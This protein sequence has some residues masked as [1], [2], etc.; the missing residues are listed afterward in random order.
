MPPLELAPDTVRTEAEIIA[1]AKSARARLWGRSVPVPIKAQLVPSTPSPP[2]DAPAPPPESE[3]RAQV[4]KLAL[5]ALSPRRTPSLEPPPDWEVTHIS[6]A[7][8]IAA[9]CR[10]FGISAEDFHERSR[11]P[12]I[13]RRRQIV[14]YLARKQGY[15]YSQIARAFRGQD[16]TT[17][18]NSV[19]RIEVLLESGDLET[20]SDVTEIATALEV[21]FPN[22]G[23]PREQKRKSSSEPPHAP[24]NGFPWSPEETAYLMKAIEEENKRFKAVAIELG[25]TERSVSYEAYLNGYQPRRRYKRQLVPRSIP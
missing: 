24:R 11:A 7:A 15:D 6:I 5:S 8:I 1:L 9:T 18:L 2:I 4:V 10:H 21:Q 23:N 17:V 13:A 19:R 14:A 16:H 20:A 22:A 25:R 12:R 3:R